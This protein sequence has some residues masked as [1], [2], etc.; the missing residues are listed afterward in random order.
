[1]QNFF[2]GAHQVPFATAAAECAQRA[3]EI[4]VGLAALGCLSN[5][6]LVT[7]VSLARTLRLQQ[8]GAYET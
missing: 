3:S 6:A 4:T 2:V 5:S 8:R 1:M 7:L